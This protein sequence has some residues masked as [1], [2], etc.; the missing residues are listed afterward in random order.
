VTRLRP[1]AILFTALA[2]ALAAPA[3]S[4]AAA[5]NGS[6]SLLAPI[7]A[8]SG[9]TKPQISVAAQQRAMR[10]L[11]NFARHASGLQPLASASALARAAGHKAADILGCNEFSHEA[12]G[13]EFT[14]WMQRF[15]YLRDGCWRAAENIAWGTRDLAAPR[16][17][18]RSWLESP[19]HREN[20]LG[21]YA[22]IGIGLRLG[23]LEDNPGAHVWVEE[24][25]SHT[26]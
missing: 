26:C 10:C 9:Q 17:I 20:I 12:C 24:F 16:A 1:I 7:S 22:Q 14:Y 2:L 23:T 19:G 13:R 18:F 15:G 4:A 21:P 11:T 3:T 5:S 25:G 6:D 8:C